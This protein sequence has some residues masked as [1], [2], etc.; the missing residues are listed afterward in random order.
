MSFAE[1]CSES[2]VKPLF[3]RALREADENNGEEN[4]LRQ[5]INAYEKNTVYVENPDK[6]HVD[7][8]VGNDLPRPEK[9][10]AQ[11]PDDAKRKTGN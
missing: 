4:A 5:A 10:F 6:K 3:E 2:N 8:T 1:I 7:I 9:S 11:M